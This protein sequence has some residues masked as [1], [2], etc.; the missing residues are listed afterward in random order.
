MSTSNNPLP[1]FNWFAWLLAWRRLIFSITYNY[2]VVMLNSSDKHVSPNQ[3]CAAE[4]RHWS[5]VARRAGLAGWWPPHSSPPPWGR[6]EGWQGSRTPAR[7]AHTGC[8]VPEVFVDGGAAEPLGSRP[9]SQIMRY[10][11]ALPDGNIGERKSG[12]FSLTALLL[13]PTT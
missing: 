10:Q 7:P 9:Q 6:E 2:K 11:A 13:S 12:H 8:S 5:G 4:C 3:S 1:V